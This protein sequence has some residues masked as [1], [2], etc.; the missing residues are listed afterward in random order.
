V[1]AIVICIG[2]LAVAFVAFGIFVLI[3]AI[4]DLDGGE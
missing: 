1:T 2:V 4:D 3:T